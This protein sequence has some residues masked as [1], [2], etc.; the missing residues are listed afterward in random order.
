[1]LPS[2]LKLTQEALSFNKQNRTR[3]LTLKAE[4]SFGKPCTIRT[5]VLKV[6]L[7]GKKMN[8]FERLTKDLCYWFSRLR[9]TF[10]LYCAVLFFY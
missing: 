7:V 2:P 8:T 4:M 6:K 9:Q 10:C 3:K 1:M 5:I